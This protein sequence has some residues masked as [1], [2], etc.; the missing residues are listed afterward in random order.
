MTL[1]AIA[2]TV[3][4]TAP[5]ARPQD[6]PPA[7]PRAGYVVHYENILEQAVAPG[8]LV[9]YERIASGPNRL[10]VAKARAGF[11]KM[12][13]PEPGPRR[14]A[15]LLNA[16]NVNV[17]NLVL[18]QG[19]TRVETLRSVESVPGFFDELPFEVGRARTTLDGLRDDMIRPLGDPRVHAALAFGAMGGPPLRP[20]PYEAG[21]L[22]AQL[23]DQCRRWVNDP[24][25]NRVE[26]D[27]LALSEIF[28]V[29]GADFSV[30]PFGGVVGFVKAYAAEG[31]PIAELLAKNPEAAITW[32]PMDWALNQAPVPAR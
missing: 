18:E 8:G 31:G 20:E 22:S 26:G 10:A 13:L 29:H 15:F 27:T 5:T 12:P 28:K 7:E 11:W 9:R 30:Q 4:A 32:L 14:L 23:D 3:A 6:V 16:Y 21:R 25:R 2:A 19:E 24:A 1:V 17:L